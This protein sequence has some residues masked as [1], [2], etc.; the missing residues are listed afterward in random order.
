MHFHEDVAVFPI[1]N[2]RASLDRKHS[3]RKTPS[4]WPYRSHSQV[5]SQN[6]GSPGRTQ[7]ALTYESKDASPT[8]ACRY[9]R[10]SVQV[11]P[12]YA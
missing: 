4:E 1:Y 6:C 7:T 11:S 5:I 8:S 2:Q 12:M 3:E 9:R 10:G